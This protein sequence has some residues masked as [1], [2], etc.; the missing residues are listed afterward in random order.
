MIVA[1]KKLNEVSV[2]ANGNSLHEFSH[3]LYPL[4]S[5]IRLLE[6]GI[7]TCLRKLLIALVLV[8]RN[9]HQDTKNRMKLVYD[10]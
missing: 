10:V 3:S 7:L 2:R 4:S 6:V 5:L 9:I 8:C 1:T